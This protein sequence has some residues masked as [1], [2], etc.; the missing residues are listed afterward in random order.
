M[1]NHMNFKV[2]LYSD[3]SQQALSAAV[4]AATLLKH[5]PNMSLTIVQI[6]ECDEGFMGTEYSWK[7]LRPKPK[8][9]YWG[10]APSAEPSWIDHWPNGPRTG[11]LNHVA[12]ES[13][14]ETN[15]QHDV[16]MRE[17]KNILSSRGINVELQILCSNTSISDTADTADL[18]LDYATRN[19]FGLIVMGEQEQSAFNWFN[20]GNLPQVVRNKSTIPVV[21]VKKLNE[22]FVDTYIL[23]KMKM[24]P[25]SASNSGMDGRSENI[26]F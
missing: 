14:L 6:K 4:Y 9:Y 19:S 12:N 18:I 1:N 3:G 26:L 5:M 11:W 25:I 22:D 10:C 24:Q 13:V 7:E 15:N 2:L 23:E 17:T 21:L 16:V 20:M 8:R